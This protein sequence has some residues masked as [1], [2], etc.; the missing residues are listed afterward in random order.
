MDS[1]DSKH[2]I[3][4]TNVLRYQNR[5]FGYIYALI[6]NMAVVEDLVQETILVMWEKYDSFEEGTNFFAWAKKIAYF[7]VINYL[8]KSHNS[9]VYF[10]EEVI[11]RIDSYSSVFE[12]ADHRF[13]ALENCM[14]KL[15]AKDKEL[16]KLKYVEDL[17][18]KEVAERLSRPVQGMYKVMAR[19]H[20]ALEDCVRF[21]LMRAE[22]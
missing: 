7:K 6:P 5:L 14:Q 12:R 2:E 22:R 1:R 10:S 18:I 19:I 17:T 9:E 8:E 4:L 20:S 13:E 16:L 3:F 21:N 11:A 15:S